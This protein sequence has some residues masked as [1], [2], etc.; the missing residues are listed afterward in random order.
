MKS[1]MLPLLLHLDMPGWEMEGRPSDWLLKLSG[2]DAHWPTWIYIYSVFC[3]SIT[4]FIVFIVP[5]LFWHLRFSLRLG[6]VTPKTSQPCGEPRTKALDLTYTVN[7]VEEMT[8][9]S[10]SLFCVSGGPTESVVRFENGIVFMRPQDL[11][12]CVDPREEEA[13]LPESK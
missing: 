13:R 9:M 10:Q 4:V 12:S 8:W 2:V 7:F 11:G 5:S 6:S 3:I 1:C